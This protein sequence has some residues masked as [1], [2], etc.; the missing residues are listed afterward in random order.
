[1]QTPKKRQREDLTDNGM[2]TSSGNVEE[3]KLNDKSDV[4][5]PAVRQKT[6]HPVDVSVPAN[7]SKLAD[8]GMVS[9]N[10]SQSA[11][12]PN[13]LAA[14]PVSGNT[15]ENTVA[16]KASSSPV[17]NN[18]QISTKA[19]STA[20]PSLSTLPIPKSKKPPLST[21]LPTVIPPSISPG[22]P[23][24]QDSN[25]G[26]TSTGHPSP[27]VVSGPA[28]PSVPIAIPASVPLPA[29]SAS[30]TSTPSPGA[31]STERL[32]P[33]GRILPKEHLSQPITKSELRELRHWV[34]DKGTDVE[35]LAFKMLQELILSP[36]LGI[37]EDYLGP[38]N[39]A[40]MK[41]MA[42]QYAVPHEGVFARFSDVR[43]VFNGPK[44]EFAEGNE[45]WM[46]KQTKEQ[47]AVSL[48]EE[49]LEFLFKPY[50][51]VEN[52]PTQAPATY[53][54]R[55]TFGS[56]PIGDRGRADGAQQSRYQD[57]VIEDNLFNILSTYIVQKESASGIIRTKEPHSDF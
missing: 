52:G 28:P 38:L 46:K 32:F 41:D 26:E 44:K 12:K 35:Q 15:K 13:A 43:K 17:V 34:F 23:I 16:M 25:A 2:A 24:P 6:S 11:V 5:R 56:R 33:N 55:G 3:A 51:D 49:N 27:G 9:N 45:E 40:L 4:S 50:H 21:A 53:P 10:P 14:E 31:I 18:E 19:P 7:T 57:K 37:R 29:A 42:D 30:A 20:G 39:R 47:L 48:F 54:T 1:M 22:A 36:I 8:M